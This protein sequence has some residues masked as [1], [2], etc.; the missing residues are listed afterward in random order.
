MNLKTCP[1]CGYVRQDDDAAPLYECPACGVVYAKYLSAQAA[2]R[3]AVEVEADRSAKDAGEA[4]KLTPAQ[5]GDPTLADGPAREALLTACRTCG[6]RVA[7]EAKSCPHCG[8]RKPVVKSPEGRGKKAVRGWIKWAGVAA[9]GL[10][11]LSVLLGDPEKPQRP[12]PVRM[13]FGP[14]AA[15]TGTPESIKTAIAYA[16]ML[17]RAGACGVDV[18]KAARAVG[19]WMSDAGPAVVMVTAE[20]MESEARLQHT[21]ETPDSCFDVIESVSKVTW[22]E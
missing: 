20:R 3:R 10:I 2:Q 15:Y 22:P 18:S 17:G 13:N 11:V 1:K 7:R 4:K 12:F 21:G 5:K 14:V 9:G 16:S 6:G 8:Q 19:Q